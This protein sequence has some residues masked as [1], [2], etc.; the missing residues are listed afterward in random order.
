MLFSDASFNEYLESIQA[1]IRR[2]EISVD[3]NEQGITLAEG[4]DDPEANEERHQA[5]VELNEAREAVEQLNIFYQDVSKRWATPESRILGH[6]ILSPP[7]NVGINN[8]CY[9]EDWAIIEVDA[10]KIDVGNFNGNAIDLG[11]H[12][13]ESDFM[14]MMCPKPRDS[15]YFMYPIYRLLMLKGIISDD[16]LRHPTAPDE[17]NNPCL[18]VIKRGRTTGVTIGCANNIFSYTRFGEQTSK[19]WVILPFNSKSGTFSKMGDSGS[20][21]VD[22]LGRIG[23]LL[24]GSAGAMPSSDITY[25]T[26]IS[27]LLKCMHDKGLHNPNINPVLT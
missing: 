24:T 21:I 10:S 19:E 22:G 9:T 20:V 25:A 1:E 18:M 23:G 4:K 11:T 3:Y 12:I 8:E 14:R 2:K 26:P 5:Q 17:N 7:I 15:N 27:F 6:V 13:S 16:E